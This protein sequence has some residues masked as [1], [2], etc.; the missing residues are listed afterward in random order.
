MTTAQYIRS[1][2]NETL[3]AIEYA[4]GVEKWHYDP[5]TKA[6]LRMQIRS[7][8]AGGLSAAQ[9][10]VNYRNTALAV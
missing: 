5:R 10:L 2:R 9:W 8:K 7:A 1:F 6:M 4:E 3:R